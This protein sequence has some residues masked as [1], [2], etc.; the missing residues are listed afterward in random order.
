MK[1]VF[2]SQQHQLQSHIPSLW[3]SSPAAL[4][5]SATKTQSIKQHTCLKNK[6]AGHCLHFYKLKHEQKLRR[7]KAKG[8]YTDVFFDRNKDQRAK[9]PKPKVPQT[10]FSH[11]TFQW[12]WKKSSTSKFVS[13]LSC[14]LHSWPFCLSQISSNLCFDDSLQ[15]IE[16]QKQ[17]P[18][19]CL[20]LFFS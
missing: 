4:T 8:K 9:K 5:C 11:S 14:H 6:Q 7:T 3:S 2:I 17:S 13:L 10:D 1:R 18:A 12:I 19:I 15:Q 16:P 20:C